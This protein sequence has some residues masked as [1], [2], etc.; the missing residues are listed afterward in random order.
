MRYLSIIR[1][2]LLAEQIETHTCP[3]T[4]SKHIHVIDPTIFF[5]E[6]FFNR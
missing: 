6:W 3:L 2:K 1:Q 4:D 5:V